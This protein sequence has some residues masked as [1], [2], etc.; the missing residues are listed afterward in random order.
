MQK[1]FIGKS[2][3]VVYSLVLNIHPREHTKKM[4]TEPLIVETTIRQFV[5][6]N[7]INYAP[8]LYRMSNEETP[9]R[10]IRRIEELSY[11]TQKSKVT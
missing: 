8:P 4:N 5:I 7:P 9:H 3:C 2:T 10:P 1:M 6:R 11:Q